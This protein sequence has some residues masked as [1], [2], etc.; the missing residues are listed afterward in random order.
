[1]YFRGVKRKYLMDKAHFLAHLETFMTDSRK[2][3]LEQILSNRTRHFTVAVEDVFQ[4][5]NTSAVVRSC[6]VFGLQDVHL[7]EQ[8]FGKRLDEKIAMGA[9]KWVDTFRYQNTHS[10]IKH[11]KEKGYQIVATTPHH[12]AVSLEDFD[13]S[14]KSAFFFGTE[15][16]GLSDEVLTQADTFLTIPM[17]GFTESLNIS[18]SVAIIIQQLMQRLR[19]SDISWKISDDQMQ[20]IRIDWALKSIRSPKDIVRRYEQLYGKPE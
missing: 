20:Q 10:C 19:A 5:H 11:L 3:R 9:Q 18:V 8:R 7:I 14:V 16:E 2:Q 13:I 15:K 6:E 12:R 1:M 4:M 17:V